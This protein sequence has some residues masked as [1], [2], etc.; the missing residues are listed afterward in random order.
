MKLYDNARTVADENQILS[1]F[2]GRSSACYKNYPHLAD[3]QYTLSARANFDLFQ[4]KHPKKTVIFI[5]GGY[6]QW[7][8]K[9]DFAFIVPDILAQDCQSILLEYNLAPHCAIADIVQQ[10]QQALDFISEQSWI[11]KDVILVGHSAGAHLAAYHL[12]HPLIS[13][14]ALISG[15]YDLAPIQ[16]T[17]LNQALNLTKKDVQQ[18]SPI[19]QSDAFNKNY[20]IVYGMLELEELQWQSQNYFKYRQSLDEEKVSLISCMDENHYSIL[21]HYFKTIFRA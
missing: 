5:H 9:S 16:N 12:N 13:S 2:Q 8:N 11:T 14:A 15:I 1:D 3:I 21:E 6:W 10:I 7:C 18:Y 17:H 19:H 4:V 20:T